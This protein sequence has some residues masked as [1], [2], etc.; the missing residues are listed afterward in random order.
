MCGRLDLRL[1]PAHYL[2]VIQ[3]AEEVMRRYYGEPEQPMRP[4]PLVKSPTEMATARWGW[5]GTGLK[6]SLLMHARIETAPSKPTWQRAWRERRGVVP[7]AGWYEGSWHVQA[8]GAHLAVLWT[9]V[10]PEDIRFVVLTQAPPAG[11]HIERF[12]I[13]LTSAGAEEWLAGSEPADQ[14][15]DFTVRG[16]GGQQTLFD[17]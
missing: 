7:V 15:T 11:Q 5:P 2:A 8:P 16:T 14:V 1:D 13:P 17:L 10:G 3:R 4:L 6:P 9:A 12:P